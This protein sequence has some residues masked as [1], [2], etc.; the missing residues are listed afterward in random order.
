MFPRCRQLSLSTLRWIVLLAPPV[1]LVLVWISRTIPRRQKILGTLAIP[2]FGILYLSAV[3][4]ALHLYAG[5]DFYE[6]RGGYW[7]SLTW[8]PTQPDFEALDRQRR[9]QQIQPPAAGHAIARANAPV[10]WTGFRGPNRDGI[11]L[12]QPI[13]TQW[14][15]RPPKLLW[16]QPIGGGY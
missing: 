13:Q 1:A 8:R 11:Y 4:T 10:Y 14:V 5:I 12:E 7:P 16:R 15:E 6:W 2:L 3:L 9:Q